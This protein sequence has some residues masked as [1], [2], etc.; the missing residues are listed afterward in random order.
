MLYTEVTNS[1]V[2]PAD[3]STCRSAEFLESVDYSTDVNNTPFLV[4]NFIL[5]NY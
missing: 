1:D 5:N 2:Q 3:A 4:D